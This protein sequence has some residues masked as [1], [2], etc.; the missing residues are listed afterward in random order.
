[1]EFVLPLNMV[2]INVLSVNVYL[3]RFNMILAIN[4]T[5]GLI[6][7]EAQKSLINFG[8]IYLETDLIFPL[9][10]F[11]FKLGVKTVESTS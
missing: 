2:V 8:L 4:R 3:F 10:G 5:L 9:S 1:M 6:L 11:P 7:S